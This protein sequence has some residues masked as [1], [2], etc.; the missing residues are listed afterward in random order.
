MFSQLDNIR[1]FA[2]VYD[3]GKVPSSN[4]ISIASGK[5]GT[6]KTFVA[7]NLAY[8][9][10]KSK[11][12]LLF[13]FD[14][15]LSNLHTIFNY[16][17]EKTL[18]AFFDSKCSLNEVI[19][20]YNENLHLVFGNPS[21]SDNNNP[22]INQLNYFF[23]AINNYQNIY[24]FIV[25]DLGA[26]IGLENLT[27]LSK[28]K[29]KLIVT[30]PEPTALMDAYM[31]IKQLKRK[32]RN[33]NIYITLNR[34]MYG[35]E[36]EISFNNLK[37]AIN[38]FLKINIEYLGS[39]PESLEIRNSIFNQSLFAN[40]ATDS[41]AFQSLNSLNEKIIKIHQLLNINQYANKSKSECSQ[42]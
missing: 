16:N 37:A 42:N 19:T 41:D 10:S 14:F 18:N 38:H 35:N 8:L 6:G 23:N 11:K 32:G 31:L 33:E 2:K 12:V 34:C 40:K 21:V 24:D 15:Q 4:T 27:I 13:D 39:I 5:G 3:E 25:F 26:G 28:T 30:T 17:P 36:G 20:K 9:L 1:E 7:A 22:S 29:M